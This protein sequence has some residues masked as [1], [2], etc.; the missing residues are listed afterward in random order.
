MF[1]AIRRGSLQGAAR[2]GKLKQDR[3]PA[4][5]SGDRMLMKHRQ[6]FAQ[7]VARR[8]VRRTL[9][10]PA[11]NDELLLEQE[12]LRHHRSYITGATEFRGHDGEVKQGE[13]RFLICGSAQDRRGAPRNV[14]ESLMRRE[15]SQFET[16]RCG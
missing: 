5:D 14:A 6:Q 12:V 4:S 2:A 7:P 10:S 9:T 16:H 13:Q 15:N 1:D 8:Q 3:A 11:Q